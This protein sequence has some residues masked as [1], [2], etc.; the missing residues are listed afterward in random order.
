VD[1]NPAVVEREGQAVSERE[2]YWHGPVFDA[3]LTRRTAAREG[4]F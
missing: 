1:R 2:V 4:A 3:F